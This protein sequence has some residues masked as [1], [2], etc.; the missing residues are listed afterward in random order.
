MLVLLFHD[1]I[2][3]VRRGVYTQEEEGRSVRRSHFRLR[4]WLDWHFLRNQMGVGGLASQQHFGLIGRHTC[5]SPSRCMRYRWCSK[6]RLRSSSRTCS[7]SATPQWT[8][9]YECVPALVC[10]SDTRGGLL[11]G[12]EVRGNWERTR[13]GSPCALCRCTLYV[14]DR[15]T[16]MVN[17][18]IQ[19]YLALLIIQPVQCAQRTHNC[20]QFDTW[21]SCRL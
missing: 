1:E 19:L 9:P 6:E 10:V 21:D 8:C 5:G 13:E 18:V 16:K 20:V 14:K 11:A 2:N 12:F 3:S 7:G 15:T 17:M 4:W